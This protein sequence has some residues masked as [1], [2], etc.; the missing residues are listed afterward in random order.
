MQKPKRVKKQA[1]ANTKPMTPE[2]KK[3]HRNEMARLRRI[4]KKQQQTQDALRLLGK[5]PD[6]PESYKT[7]EGIK[8][9]AA[10]VISMVPRQ[11]AVATKKGK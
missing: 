6:A 7:E 9:T 4:R 1:K 3:K 2:E 11:K 10:E 8:K 5:F